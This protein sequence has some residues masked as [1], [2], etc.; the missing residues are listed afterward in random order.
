MNYQDYIKSELLILIPVLYF[1]GIVLKKSSIPDKFIPVA[2]G[3]ISIL[4]SL[5]WTLATTDITCFRDIAL[6]LFTSITQGILLAGTSVY[7]NQIYV[8]SKKEE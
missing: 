4:L 2:L 3:V 1:I 8:Q 6:A 7:A 5:I